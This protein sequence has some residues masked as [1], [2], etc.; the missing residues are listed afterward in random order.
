MGLLHGRMGG[1]CQNCLYRNA[2]YQEKIDPMKRL[3]PC[4]LQA[5][6]LVCLLVANATA[7]DESPNKDESSK[8][9]V[10]ELSV[11]ELR[12]Y[13]ELKEHLKNKMRAYTARYRA[14]A[15]KE[16]KMEVVKTRPSIDVYRPLLSKLVAE[17]TE[18]EADKILTW[19]WHGERGKKDAPLM[20]KLLIEHHS[21]AKMLTKFVPRF[22]WH[23][24]PAQ[25]EPLFR[26][27]LEATNVEAVKATTSFSLL[28]LLSKKAKT[29]EGKEAELLQ[30]EI[31]SL[32]KSIKTEYAEFTD[33]VG[34]P[35][36]ER[37]EG[38]EFSKKL[39]IGKPVPDIVGSD[40]DGVEFKLSDYKDN[41]VMVSFWGQW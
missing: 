9:D 1:L 33:L 30:A 26:K 36:G 2:L 32:S 22:G 31:A 25:A 23:L 3:L 21:Q 34:T 15:S 12:T 5:L 28:D 8:R 39:A 18:E 7:Q 35:L 20:S 29:A 6:L 4:C 24:S 16:D 38:I 10:S 14:A 11:D 41:V 13:G 19:W 40:L 27:V 37:L 17:G